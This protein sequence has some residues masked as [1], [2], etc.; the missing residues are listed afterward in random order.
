MHVL[1]SRRSIDCNVSETMLRSTLKHNEDIFIWILWPNFK[2]VQVRRLGAFAPIA[3]GKWATMMSG[4]SSIPPASVA[5][6]VSDRA[7]ASLS[8]AASA[9]NTW[10]AVV[11]PFPVH[12]V[13][14]CDPSD[15][16]CGYH[17]TVVYIPALKYRTTV[18][19]ISDCL[20]YRPLNFWDQ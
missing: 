15:S 1:R 10:R 11:V 12:S 13:P 7:M 2:F 17:L 3:P 18:L 14:S 5:A 4:L 9:P 6:A 8:W 20:L 19:S 16:A